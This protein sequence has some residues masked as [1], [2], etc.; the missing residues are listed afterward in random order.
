MLTI[1]G[2]ERDPDYI[3]NASTQVKKNQKIIVM[4]AIGEVH[5]RSRFV[6][7]HKPDEQRHARQTVQAHTYTQQQLRKKL[8]AAFLLLASTASTL[9]N[10]D[11][12]C[13]HKTSTSHESYP[14]KAFTK[15]QLAPQA[16][17]LCLRLN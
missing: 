4:C 6:Q 13:N 9:C 15:P 3:E 16:G 17:S 12:C 10:N 11:C 8:S 14:A 7:H 5:N 1:C 2:A